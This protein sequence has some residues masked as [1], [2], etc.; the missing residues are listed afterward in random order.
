MPSVFN[1]VNTKKFR[2]LANAA[3]S[4]GE[5]SVGKFIA[6]GIKFGYKTVIGIIIGVVVLVGFS[7]G[8]LNF[9]KHLKND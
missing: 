5:D 3:A 1:E 9:R 8:S 4:K 6:F 2:D 7:L